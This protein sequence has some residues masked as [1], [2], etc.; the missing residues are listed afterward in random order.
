M[1][2]PIETINDVILSKEEISKLSDNITAGVRAGIED[3]T[4]VIVRIEFLKKALEAAKKAL[5]EEAIDELDKYGKEGATINGV[6]IRTK[7]AGVKYDYSNCEIW[8]ELN[9]EFKKVQ[10]DRKDLEARLKTVKGTEQI[11]IPDGE[12]VDLVQ[13]IKTSS[14]TVEFTFPK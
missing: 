3:P 12:I 5:L 14:T 10:Q 9:E 13:P 2:N 8:N 11:L 4:N 1:N 7:E 6:K